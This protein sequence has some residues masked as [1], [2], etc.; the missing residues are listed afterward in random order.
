[1]K[2]KLIL[3]A[4]LL[5]STATTF[6]QKKRNDLYVDLALNIPGISATYDHRVMR[7][8]EVGGGISVYNWN[9]TPLNLSTAIYADVRPYWRIGRSLLFIHGDVGL[10]HYSE[11][12][13]PQYSDLSYSKF[14][15]HTALG[16]G[17]G[18][19][20]TRRGAGPYIT[21]AMRGYT[22]VEHYNNPFAQ[23]SDAGM[24]EGNSVLALGF[25]F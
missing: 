18:Y 11:K 10:A 14:G 20:I 25:K 21:L 13:N 19:M 1:V 17:Y 23:H 15:I 24:F 4:L 7:H 9:T 8:L 5:A 22:Y 16:I 3:I 12:K 2:K 6:A